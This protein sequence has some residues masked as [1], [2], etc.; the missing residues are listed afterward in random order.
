M[1]WLFGVL[2]FLPS[3]SAAVNCEDWMRHLQQDHN[4]WLIEKK[5]AVSGSFDYQQVKDT[6]LV[7]A[8]KKDSETWNVESR[9]SGRL[10]LIKNEN[11]GYI[12][13]LDSSQKCVN[14]AGTSYSSYNK[15]SVD[16]NYDW[17]ICEKINGILGK[18]LG[19][20]NSE[21][22]RNAIRALNP[23]D[24]AVLKA[25]VMKANEYPFKPAQ[26]LTD[27]K[28]VADCMGQTQFI[29]ETLREPSTTPPSFKSG[30]R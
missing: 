26:K 17:R 18:K 10:I 23:K 12:I 15:D 20:L 16:F 5:N 4:V 19:N 1:K 13:E 8:T 2:F 22:I 24:Q 9:N 30:I 28:L 11:F 14:S 3:I 27:E 21:T 29:A 25:Q 7:I 6:S